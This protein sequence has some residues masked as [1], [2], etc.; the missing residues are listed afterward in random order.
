MACGTLGSPG[1]CGLCPSSFH[2]A[3]PR[4][5]VAVVCYRIIFVF[6]MMHDPWHW[7]VPKN[8]PAAQLAVNMPTMMTLLN[9]SVACNAVSL[10]AHRK[11]QLRCVRARPAPP[12]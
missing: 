3:L 10:P 2:F 1:E 11:S 7:H 9:R 4:A 6:H 5:S 12:R 8:G